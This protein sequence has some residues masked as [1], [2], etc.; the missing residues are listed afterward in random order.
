MYI[1]ISSSSPVSPSVTSRRHTA[2]VRLL[3][4]KQQ[5]RAIGRDFSTRFLDFKK[6]VGV[7]GSQCMVDFKMQLIIA[8]AC[9]LVLEL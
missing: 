4:K 7:R 3:D 8:H 1:T 6:E 9:A 2:A 5:Y